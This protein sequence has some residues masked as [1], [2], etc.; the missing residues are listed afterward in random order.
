MQWRL[1][2]DEVAGFMDPAVTAWSEGY[3]RILLS[4]SESAIYSDLER[5]WIANFEPH[6]FHDYRLVSEDL[7]SYTLSIDGSVVYTGQ[8]V[9]P[10][11][12]QASGGAIRQ[13]GGGVGQFG[14]MSRLEWFRN[15]P[16]LC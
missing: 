7:L 5:I 11:Y 10:S 16:Q 3:G 13:W 14:S 8:M 4:Y 15:P 1:R 6:V 9:S 2:V 12:T